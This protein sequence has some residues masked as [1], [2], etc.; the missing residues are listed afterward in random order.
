MYSSVSQWMRRYGV[1]LLFILPALVAIGAV[2]VYPMVSSFY[3]S[4]HDIDLTKPWRGEIFVG[5]KNYRSILANSAFWDSVWRTAYFSVVSVGLELFIGFISALL[6]NEV[7]AG[8]ST[9]RS[10][11]LIPWALLTM[12]NGLMWMWIFNPH[13]GMFNAIL[14]KLGLI[15]SYRVWLADPFWAMHAV[16]LADVW[17]MA[18]FMTLLILAGLQPISEDVYDAAEVDGASTWTKIRYIVG[19]LLRPALLVAVVLRTMGAFKVF[20]IIYIMTSGGP[21]IP[22]KCSRSTH[23][24]RPFGITASA[25]VRGILAD[26]VST[27]DLDCSLH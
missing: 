19:P 1:G 7:F 11:L 10:F 20:D 5:L 17:K 16:I 4:L 13:Y 25:W 12:T 15:D 6:L 22:R 26:H 9:V 24:N 14:T 27:P 18:P 8:R 3:L 21:R 2:F 23:T